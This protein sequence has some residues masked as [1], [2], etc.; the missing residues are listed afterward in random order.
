MAPA[1][2]LGSYCTNGASPHPA[3]HQ[4]G[5][6]SLSQATFP[7]RRG[8]VWD[9]PPPPPLFP[10]LQSSLQIRNCLAALWM[11]KSLL[12]A[13]W[14]NLRFLHASIKMYLAFHLCSLGPIFCPTWQLLHQSNLCNGSVCQTSLQ[15]SYSKA[16]TI[17]LA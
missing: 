10:F 1:C 6:P 17:D 15:G 7:Q 12:V 3:P 2:A 4:P 11:S 5:G 14:L 8:P 9:R 13:S 16:V